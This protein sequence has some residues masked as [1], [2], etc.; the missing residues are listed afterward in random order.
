MKIIKAAAIVFIIVLGA[1]SLSAK[2]RNTNIVLYG[3][4][5]LKANLYNSQFQNVSGLNTCCEEFEG[6]FGVAYGALAGIEFIQ[7]KR[8]FGLQRSWF[9]NLSYENLSGEIVKEEHVAN[10]IVGNEYFKGISEHRF[11]ANLS[12]VFVQPGL[13]LRPFAETPLSIRLGVGAGILI[14]KSYDYKEVLLKPEEATFETGTDERAE[15]SSDIEDAASVLIAPFASL[16]Y[17]AFK[18]GAWTFSPELSFSYGLTS[19]LPDDE[20]KINSVSAGVVVSYR[21]P[22][23]DLSP[24][25]PAPAPTD[26]P[27]PEAP[28]EIYDVAA[29]LSVKADN[30]RLSDGETLEIPVSAEQYIEKYLIKPTVFFKNGSADVKATDIANIDS[31]ES[32]QNDAAPIIL[33]YMRKNAGV[34]AKMTAIANSNDND[35][36]AK[37]RIESLTEYFARNGI[38]ESRFESTIVEVDFSKLRHVE[39]VEENNAVEF[40]FTGAQKLIPHIAK[41][42]VEYDSRPIEIKVDAS[43]ESDDPEAEFIGVATLGDMKKE[44]GANGIKF[45]Y[46]KKIQNED[47]L[48]CDKLKISGIARTSQG[49]SKDIDREFVI[50]M[51]IENIEQFSSVVGGSSNIKKNE[52]I[53]GFFNF[54]ESE[55]SSINPSAVDVAQKAAKSGAKIE[56]FALTDSLGS[57]TLNRELARRRAYEALK[58]LKFNENDVEIIYPEN[59][60]FDNSTPAGRISNRSVVLRIITDKP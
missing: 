50:C 2:E 53:L 17:D 11:D 34:R 24:P 43:I 55:F 26:L 13:S 15:T 47:N 42:R 27:M 19:V 18:S 23:P 33:E 52:Y 32:A 14:G 16:R 22:K 4:L 60:F 38:D 8:L 28:P 46:G 51:K 36:L 12:A 54:Y 25:A 45:Q 21:V 20:W 7:E 9:V 39:L 30:R 10:V 6:G 59:Y 31:Q 56:L 57:A 48:G 37:R 3:G 35:D 5:N 49:K 44:F 1:I 40:E 58:L 41:K 29:S